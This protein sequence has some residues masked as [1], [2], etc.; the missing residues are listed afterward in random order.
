MEM[1][2]SLILLFAVSVAAIVAFIVLRGR[3]LG[4]LDLLVAA[5]VATPCLWV[6]AW[7]LGMYRQTQGW[8]ALFPLLL[9][10]LAAPAA[11]I[12]M[13]AACAIALR[14]FHLTVFGRDGFNPDMLASS[15]LGL[16]FHLLVPL[17]VSAVGGPIAGLLAVHG[18]RWQGLALTKPV[19][20]MVFL[21]IAGTLVAFGAVDSTSRLVQALRCRR[22]AASSQ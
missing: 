22:E 21:A 6:A 2:A 7:L 18:A 9:L 13:L 17:T 11:A 5:A 19:E 3:K 8:P 12:S 14:L 1:S 10:V 16:A 20:E 4:W 15:R